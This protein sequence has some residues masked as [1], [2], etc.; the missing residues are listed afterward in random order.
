M[1]ERGRTGREVNGIMARRLTDTPIPDVVRT[2]RAERRGRVVGEGVA[3]ERE[4]PGPVRERAA[5]R[6]AHAV[7]TALMVLG[8]IQVL[9]LLGVESV[10]YVHAHTDVVRLQGQVSRLEAEA[11]E[12]QA[13]ADHANDASY[14]ESLARLQGYMYPDEVRAIS[15]DA[16]TTPPA[17][18]PLPPTVP[19]ATP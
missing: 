16:P 17:P 10:R 5:A 11:A 18:A 12:L 2:E 3:A 1:D 9:F 19:G 15:S 7:V 8:S 6:G 13:V 14:R 4:G